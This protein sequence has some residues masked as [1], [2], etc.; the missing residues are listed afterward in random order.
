M[1]FEKLW[2][3]VLCYVLPASV[4]ALLPYSELRGSDHIVGLSLVTYCLANKM[5]EL[6]LLLQLLG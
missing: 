5:P 1:V 4:A 2:L 6:K 3:T